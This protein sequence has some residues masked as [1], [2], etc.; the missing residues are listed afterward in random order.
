MKKTKKFKCPFKKNQLVKVD[1]IPIP[2]GQE[3]CYP[4]EPGEVLLFLGEVRQMP[5][6]CIV[7]NKKGQTWWGYHTVNFLAL[8]D[9][10]I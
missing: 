2:E 9:D 1:D 10:E 8:E 3:C 6:H 7:V 4:F 5:G